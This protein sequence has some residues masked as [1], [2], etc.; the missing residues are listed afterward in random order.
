ME[1]KINKLNNKHN[2]KIYKK[3]RRKKLYSDNII[4]LSLKMIIRLENN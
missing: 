3:G 2:H 1:N 4:N